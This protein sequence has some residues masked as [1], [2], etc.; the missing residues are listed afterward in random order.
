MI[1]RIDLVMVNRANNNF[2]YYVMEYTSDGPDGDPDIR[3]QHGRMLDYNRST[4]EFTPKSVRELWASELS[5]PPSSTESGMQNWMEEQ[6]DK[7]VHKRDYDVVAT[8]E[9]LPV[10]VFV[11][12]V[13]ESVEIIVRKRLLKIEA[14]SS[15]KKY[16]S[17]ADNSTQ[18]RLNAIN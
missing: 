13:L 14:V 18:D 17:I 12:E 15:K 16:K 1:N 6:R 2:K 4:G 8:V 3:I 11:S 10:N 7:K 5:K 9:D